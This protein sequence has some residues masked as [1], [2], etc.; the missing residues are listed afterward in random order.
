MRRVERERPRGHLGHADPAVD[1]GQSA[2]EQAV[3]LLERIDDDDV[4]GELES[5]LDG[6]GQPPFDAA[7]HDH[8]VHDHFDRVIAASIELDVLFERAELSVDARFGEP[9][10]AQVRQLLLE[11]ALAASHDRGEHVDPRILGDRA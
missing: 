6:L 9:P 11:L 7:A 4:L 1:A 8:A 5:R 2:R 3:A 10:A